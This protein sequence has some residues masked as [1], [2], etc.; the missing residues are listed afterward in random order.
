MGARLDGQVASAPTGDAQV[1]GWWG[2][3]KRK[4]TAKAAS[5]NRGAVTCRARPSANLRQ[6]RDAAQAAASALDAAPHDAARPADAVEAQVAVSAAMRS[7]TGAE[8]LTTR[9][10][11]ISD[12][13]RPNPALTT[14]VRDSGG[15]GGPGPNALHDPGTDHLVSDPASVPQV[16]ANY[17]RN[18]SA[19]PSEAELPAAVKQQ[20]QAAGAEALWAHPLQLPAAEALDE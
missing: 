12:R 1:P 17:W 8:M 15:D 7:E 14:L 18:V 11:W 6:L 19:L 10:A 4:C 16:I 13:K 5:L 9:H 20:A 3:F 2:Q